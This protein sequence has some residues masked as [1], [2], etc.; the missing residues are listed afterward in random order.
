LPQQD[1]GSSGRMILHYRVLRKLGSGGMGDVYL[2]E[3]TRL[4]RNVALKLLPRGGEIDAEARARFKFEARAASALNHPNILTIYEIGQAGEDEFI[5]M[6]LVDGETVR[7]RLL[8]GRMDWWEALE[9][10]A[11][12]ACGLAAAHGA[13]IVHRDVKPENIM[14]RP[15]GFVKILD[16]GIARSLGP[17]RLAAPDDATVAVSTTTP[18]LILGTAKYMS[19]EQARGLEIDGRSDLFSLGAVLYE[20]VGGRP[21][22]AGETASDMMAAILLTEPVSVGS[23]VPGLPVEVEAIIRK[24]IAKDRERRYQ[25]ARE[26]EADL[27]TTARTFGGERTAINATGSRLGPISSSY[28]AVQTV[29]S[30]TSTTMRRR[31][32][33]GPVDSVAVLPL[34]NTSDD[35][36]TEFLADGLTDALIY[37]LSRLPRLK[38]MARSTVARYAGRMLDPLAIGGELGVRSVLTGRIIRMGENLVV[39]AE[40]VDAMDGTQ[41]WGGQFRR[42]FKEVLT[43]EEEISGEISDALRVK[44]SVTEKKRAA[45]KIP[46]NS[47][48]YLAYL[49]G[50]HQW[51]RRTPDALHKAIV[52]FNEALGADPTYARA[53][54][55]LADSYILLSWFSSPVL[56]PLIAMP[57]ARDAALKALELEHRLGETHVALAMVRL[58]YDW[59]AADAEAEFKKALELNPDSAIVQHF[60]TILL[61]IVGRREEAGAANRRAIELEPFSMIMNTTRGWMLLYGRQ[62]A[63]AIA[64]LRRTVEVDTSFY[65]AWL[66]LGWALEQNG[67]LEEAAAA[68]ARARGIN[69]NP[70]VHA[71]E[72]HC[73]AL[74]GRGAAARQILD[75]LYSISES[76]Y[77]SPESYAVVHA[78]LGEIDLAFE[79]LDKCCAEKAGYLGFLHLDSRLDPLRVDSRFHTLVRRVGLAPRP[80]AP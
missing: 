58:L 39:K 66:I 41:L 26:V 48:A 44:L 17:V 12:V 57:R 72:A 46:A 24:A 5:S 11:Q 32:A 36:E 7:Q 55:G 8:R 61:F 53:Y 78:A 30:V 28:A 62:T 25:T 49:K 19:P 2:A 50:R 4:L 63:A 40:L 79:C 77:V 59:N 56:S 1:E 60:Y 71:A 9:V 80:D 54:A 16:F 29:P 23:L 34:E 14:I 47:E 42:L 75:S 38:V 69:N 68:F 70:V 22:F 13:G 33:R 10:A 45:R 37:N 73:H 35:S 65:T 27:R 64:D 31:R 52:H 21:P 20:M 67:D 43:L 15:D 3:D 74:A 76:Q 18:G 6:E 51:N